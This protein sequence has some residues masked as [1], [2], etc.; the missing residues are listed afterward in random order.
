MA[1]PLRAATLSPETYPR[2]ISPCSW[3]IW[4]KK[5][6][7]C[8]TELEIQWGNFSVSPN[9]NLPS[10]LRTSKGCSAHTEHRISSRTRWEGGIQ[11]STQQLWFTHKGHLLYHN[12]WCFCSLLLSQNVKCDSFLGYTL[13]ELPS[14]REQSTMILL[15]EAFICNL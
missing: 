3:A 12:A 9:S 13:N 10:G 4:L 1:N 8:I 15:D 6:E 2:T 5:T 7:S 11:V 14:I